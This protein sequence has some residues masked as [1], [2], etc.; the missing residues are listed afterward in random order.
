MAKQTLQLQTPV[1]TRQILSAAIDLTGRSRRDFAEHAGM[2][3]PNDI[4]RYLQDD[5]PHAMAENLVQYLRGN[6][7]DFRLTLPSYKS[8]RNELPVQRI[9]H[10]GFGLS[11][12][13]HLAS[14]AAAA[15]ISKPHIKRL[16]DGATSTTID[17]LLHL[18][19][20]NNVPFSFE[21]TFRKNAQ[22]IPDQ[23]AALHPA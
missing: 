13:K 10:L 21:M 20:A 9:V 3:V 1:T 16:W 17:H 14:F 7:I 11:G 6:K 2:P 22:S 19:A 15:N 4:F 12:N 8:I 18:L 5:G 23:Q